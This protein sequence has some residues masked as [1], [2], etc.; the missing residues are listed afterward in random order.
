[1]RVQNNWFLVVVNSKLR[2][3]QVLNSHK[4]IDADIVQPVTKMVKGLHCYL[5]LLEGSDKKKYHWWL[6]FNV[7]NWVIHMLDGLP[8]QTDRTSSGLFLL[9]YMEYWN[10]RRL[11]KSF[12]QDLINGF[13]PKL[14]ALLFKSDL[15]EEKTTIIEKTS[16]GSPEI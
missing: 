9:K 11:E 13:R 10:G 15:N 3:I 16:I 1:M 6:D 14:P 2:N 8:Q 5:A 4:S 12:T 7:H